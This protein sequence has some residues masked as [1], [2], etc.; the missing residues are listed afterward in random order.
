MLGGLFFFF[1]LGRMLGM[2]DFEDK[3]TGVL[4]FLP[5]LLPG[6]MVA[7]VGFGGKCLGLLLHVF[8][9]GRT[10][11]MVGFEGKV[12]GISL[13]RLSRG[14]HETQRRSMWREGSLI[15][16]VDWEA[17]GRLRSF[18]RT[19]T[20]LYTYIYTV[21]YAVMEHVKENIHKT[22]IYTITYAVMYTC[23]GK[24][25]KCYLCTHIYI[26]TLLLTYVCA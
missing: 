8:L 25:S 2:V 23:K 1:A 5:V 22:Y 18:K 9:P 12:G 19:E 6:R 24:Q 20:H 10:G 21:T 16:I 7:M 3:V 15:V 26:Y 13:T 4:L 11:G 14:F 17:P